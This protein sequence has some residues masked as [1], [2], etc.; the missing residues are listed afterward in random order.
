MYN[1][2]RNSTV[3]NNDINYQVV[4]LSRDALFKLDDYLIYQ[5]SVILSQLE[6]LN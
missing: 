5:Y 6:A 3:N 4:C 1:I 2:I